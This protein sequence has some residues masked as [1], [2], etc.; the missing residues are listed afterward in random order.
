MSI[1]I[2]DIAR[3]SGYAVGT[4]SRVLNNQP[5]VSE[6]ARQKIMEVV[7]RHHFKLNSNAKHLKQQASNAIAVIVKGSQNMLF[8]SILGQLQGEIGKKGYDCLIYY[9]NEIENEME[10]ALQVIKER[11]PVGIMFLGSNH[12]FFRRQFENVKIPCIFVTNSAKELN[13]ENLS[14]VTTDDC[15]AGY[16]AVKH[17]IEQGHRN[18]GILGGYIEESRT[19]AERYKGCKKA[20]EEYGINF[21]FYRNYESTMFSVEYGYAAAKKLLQRAN[22]ITALFAMSD[23]MAIGAMRAITDMGMK[24]PQDISLV[25]F[26]GIDLSDYLVPK[27]TTIRQSRE[28]IATRSVEILTDIIDNKKEAVYEV[29]PFQIKK[30]EST[31]KLSLEDK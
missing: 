31:R 24:V 10:T 14:S 28:Q 8:A 25:G 16:A 23:V 6:T 4:V 19:A 12:Q 2:K 13:F 17:L 5:D 26:D 30:G 1:T 20:F 7:N 22:D 3:E 29:V 21:D 18:I 15:D 11:R 9:I 27:L